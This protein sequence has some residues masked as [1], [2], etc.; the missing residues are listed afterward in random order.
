M[1]NLVLDSR[2]H[3]NVLKQWDIMEKRLALPDQNYVALK[4]RPTLA[5]LSY[6]P[7]AMPWMFKFLSVDIKEWPH[8]QAWGDRMIERPAVKHVLEVA[9]TYGH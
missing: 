4:D 3:S 7:F 2:L 1:T 9:P 6:F 8:I 5:D